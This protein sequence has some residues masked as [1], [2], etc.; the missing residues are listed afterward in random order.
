MW[1]ALKLIED[2]PYIKEIYD[3]E[4]ADYKIKIEL[5]ESDNTFKHIDIYRK[6][7]VLLLPFSFNVHIMGNSGFPEG[8]RDVEKNKAEAEIFIAEEILYHN[9]I[10]FIGKYHKTW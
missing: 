2:N 4:R 1:S 6:V 9:D 5:N 8:N 3:R 7:K 10:H